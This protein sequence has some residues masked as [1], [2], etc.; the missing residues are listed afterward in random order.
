MQIVTKITKDML[1]SDVISL[2]GNLVP[3]FFAHGL[4]CLG[5]VLAKYETLEQACLAHQIDI[6][7]LLKDLNSYLESGEF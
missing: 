5:C 2:D 4:H 3:I 6:E 7:D 1:V